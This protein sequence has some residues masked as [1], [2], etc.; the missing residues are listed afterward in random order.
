MELNPTVF[1]NIIGDETGHYVSQNEVLQ[2]LMAT[3][4]ESHLQRHQQDDEDLSCKYVCGEVPGHYGKCGEKAQLEMIR[5]I[6]VLDSLG[7][8]GVI[9]LAV[10][11]SVE[12][13][14]FFDPNRKE[15]NL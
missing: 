11:I 9:S 15:I 12:A 5:S 13:I 8:V 7:L 10:H 4:N 1:H 6:V 14:M 3:L 2:K